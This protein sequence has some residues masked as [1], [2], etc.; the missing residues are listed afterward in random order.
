MNVCKPNLKAALSESLFERIPFDALLD[1]CLS[2]ELRDGKTV[3]GVLKV[4][5]LRT[6]KK[7]EK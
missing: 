1:R 5:A 3:A 6:R 2:G 7:E 4:Y